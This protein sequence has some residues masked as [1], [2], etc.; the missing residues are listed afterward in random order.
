MAVVVVWDLRTKLAGYLYKIAK[1]KLKDEL[2][3]V[4]SKLWALK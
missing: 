3:Q 1:S 4:G 2:G